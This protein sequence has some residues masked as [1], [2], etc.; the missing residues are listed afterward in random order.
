MR[1]SQQRCSTAIYDKQK[2]NSKMIS[3]KILSA[4][5]KEENV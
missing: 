4:R 1:A 5:R 3:L 2:K